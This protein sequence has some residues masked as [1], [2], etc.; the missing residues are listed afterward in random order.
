MA[1]R[2]R[3]LFN[4]I[5]AVGLTAS[6]SLLLFAL[7]TRDDAASTSSDGGP[8][9]SSAR[10]LWEWER[11]RDPA[12][13]TIPENIREREIAFAL[14]H[15]T[16]E[17]R[18]G[19]FKAAGI[20]DN[21][22]T[23]RGP[24]NVG[25]R[26]RAVAFDVTGPDTIVAGGVS[27]GMWRSTNAGVSWTMVT[28][29]DQLPSVT[30]I[31]QDRRPGKTHIWYAGT[32][33][34]Y[35]NS[36]SGGGAFWHGDGIYKSVDNGRSWELLQSTSSASP[37]ILNTRDNVWR[38]VADPSTSDQ[39]VLYAALYGRITRSTDGGETWTDVI[40]PRNV[41]S[42]L[43]YCT[44]IAVTDD[45]VVYVTLSSE[46][47]V[48]G[49][50]RSTNGVNF[51]DISPDDL[52]G[53][54]NRIVI[55]IAPSNPNV[56]YFIG[57]TPGNGY[58]GKNFRGDSSWSSLWKY[59]YSSGD[60]TGAGGTWENRSANLPDYG[61]SNGS[62]F[63]QGG[64][65][66]HV[67]VKPDD[68]NTIFIGGTNLYRS[69]DGFASTENSAWIG[70]FKNWKRDSSVVEDY[71]YPNHHADQHDVVFSPIDPDVMLSASDGGV[72]LTHDCLA[73]SIDWLSLN[74]GYLTT[75]FYTV[76][77]DHGRPGDQA[78][79]GGL[80]DNG[81]WRTTSAD[82]TTPWRLTG[83]SDGAYCAI[84]DGGDFLVASKQQGRIFRIDL[85]AAGNETGSTRIDPA[86]P[87]AQT[88]YR[89]INPL[90]L[91]PND[92][93][94]IYVPINRTIWR[95]RDITTIPLD[96]KAATPIGWDSLG[97]SFVGD[98]NGVITAIAATTTAP[99]NRIWYGTS[100]GR[101]FR[102]DE[103]LGDESTTLNVTAANFP[104]GAYVSCIAV[105][106]LDGERAIVVFSNYAVVSLFETTDGGATWRPI[107]G[108]LEQNPNGSGAGPS[109][110]WASILHRGGGTVTLVATST[111]LYSTTAIDGNAT[112]WTKEGAGTIGAATVV[113][114]IDVRQSDGFVAIATHGFG[115]FS[116]TF[117]PLGVDD[118]DGPAA[119]LRFE[120]SAPNPMRESAQVSF[121]LPGTRTMPV[122]LSLY[123]AAGEKVGTIYQ[124][125]M[126][127]G[128]QS[129]RI[130]RG[131]LAAGTYFCRLD[132]GGESVA[133]AVQVW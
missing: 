14:G 58:L 113:D 59:T 71:S 127:P 54:F 107:S 55:G 43:S 95:N 108:N 131:D 41:T 21:G 125:E 56:V 114:M 93:R 23:H 129:V 123:S 72:H 65:D 34:L 18:R 78:I 1:H 25:G 42:P 11:M 50:Y 37:Q 2:S 82:G 64:Y 52:T 33:E 67:R 85:D 75:Q 91:D 111:G 84:A 27:G 128:R 35:G 31:T 106:P 132:A 16:R 73:D 38:V 30:S 22:W 118:V 40:R 6:A 45:G 51:V 98:G 60:G 88:D 99:A 103:A 53:E 105:D 126:A 28:R 57:E 32:G 80:Q 15:P 10:L 69:T 112:V 96:N 115:V 4:R 26:T 116:T 76:A 92:E 7:I 3:L 124:G 61:G 70:G 62:L 87:D 77:I 94:T 9:F 36:A 74:S 133:M 83:S 13:G 104:N 44:D 12:T 121:T 130:D 122:T 101:V 81:T 8:E 63:T 20:A 110:R 90:I 29:L 86:G 109:V 48:P 17:S 119:G 66:L 39:D 19:L 5:A 89:F 117:A 97:G 46:G 120:G 47:S 102:L 79:V 49:I 24:W 68:E 100:N